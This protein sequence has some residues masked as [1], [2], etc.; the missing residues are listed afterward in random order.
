MSNYGAPRTKYGKPE[1][2]SAQV[3]S[4]VEAIVKQDLEVLSE[5]LSAT[6]SP[7]S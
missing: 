2:P 3:K 6:G 1:E 5:Q 7:P 4:E